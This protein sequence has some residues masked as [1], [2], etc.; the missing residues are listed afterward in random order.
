MYLGIDTSNYTTSICLING[1]GKVFQEKKILEVKHGEKGLRQS[2]AVF[3]HTVNLPVLI[4][5][6]NSK[7]NLNGRLEAVSV[8]SRPRNVDGSYMPCF[9]T[10]VNTAYAVSAFSG[11]KYYET[12]HQIGHILSVL[13]SENK[14]ELIREPFVAL[15]LSGGT[16]ELL[17]VKPDDTD[18][19]KAEVIA[20]SLDLKAGQAIDR[21]GVLLG[22]DFPCGAELDKLSL[23]SNQNYKHKP[24][25][26]GLD[27]S[28]SGIE[29]KAVNL[30][31]LCTP[32]Q[33]IAKFVL[34]YIADSILTML[35]NVFK[36][37]PLMPVVFSGGV[38]SNTIL[39]NTVKSKY[40]NAYFASS[41]FSCDNALGVAVYGYL[42]DKLNE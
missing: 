20:K 39:R 10:G 29:N 23:N 28:L 9:L 16:T 12:S 15:H 32:P 13:F 21:T 2:D 42:K 3:Q 37:Y 30:H 5:K 33:D 25:V 8:S 14:L 4:E 27:I 17:L 6:L 34:T 1:E 41:Q 31:K 38:S 11:A 24:S 22:L 35:N 7:V 26:K 19:I 36:E 40:N 18:I